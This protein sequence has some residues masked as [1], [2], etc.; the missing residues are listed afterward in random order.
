MRSRMRGRTVEFD[1]VALAIV[2]TNRLDTRETLQRPGKAD[3]RVLPAREEHKCS[4]G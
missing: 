1:G 4:I 2:E 3:R